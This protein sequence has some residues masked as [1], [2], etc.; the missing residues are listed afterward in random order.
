[1]AD[2]IFKSPAPYHIL[3][4]VNLKVNLGIAFSADRQ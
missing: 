3:A 2:S 4:L 1:M